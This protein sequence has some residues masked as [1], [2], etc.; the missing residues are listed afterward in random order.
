L[1]NFGN[2]FLLPCWRSGCI[3]ARQL[4]VSHPQ[5]N[6]TDGVHLLGMCW[7]RTLIIQ[8]YQILDFIVDSIKL[9]QNQYFMKNRLTPHFLR[10]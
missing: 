4:P 6:V 7:P 1:L 10:F 8:C 2:V 9:N 3:K 5:E